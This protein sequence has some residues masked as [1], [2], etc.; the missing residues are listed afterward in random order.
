MQSA[1]CVFAHCERDPF[2]W[3]DTAIWLADIGLGLSSPVL[4][5]P[6]WP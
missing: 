2:L 5:Q 6:K 3:V 1:W 4:S